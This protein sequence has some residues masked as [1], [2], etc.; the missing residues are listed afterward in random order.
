M[1]PPSS[2][3]NDI[4]LILLY[5]VTTWLL[6]QLGSLWWLQG[7]SWWN[8]V[9]FVMFCLLFHYLSPSPLT[10]SS[11]L[12]KVCHAHTLLTLSILQTVQ[13]GCG[14]WDFLL[15]DRLVVL[16]FCLHF[17]YLLVHLTKLLATVWTRLPDSHLFPVL[18]RIPLLSLS[19]HY[20]QQ[21]HYYH[22]YQYIVSLP[23][24]QLLSWRL[25]FS[26]QAEVYLDCSF[27]PT[28][29][30]SM[31]DISFVGILRGCGVLSCSLVVCLEREVVLFAYYDEDT[32][33]KTNHYQGLGHSTLL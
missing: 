17:S 5:L 31:M 4:T 12:E 11:I 18:S 10:P 23:L 32:E 16:I 8:K 29:F 15:V 6:W 7:V 9:G 24:H 30:R 21:Y 2:T 28:I 25:G 14:C 20:Y 19:R 27:C 1:H 13:V 3:S 33:F 26:N 22:Y